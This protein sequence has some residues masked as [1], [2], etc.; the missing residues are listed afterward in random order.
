MYS[1]LN[2]F[3]YWTLNKHDYYYYCAC[4]TFDSDTTCNIQK[5]LLP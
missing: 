4:K 1:P 2:L 5:T 3:G